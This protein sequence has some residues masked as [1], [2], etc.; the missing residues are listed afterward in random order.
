MGQSNQEPA[1]FKTATEDQE[2]ALWDSRNAT[3]SRYG[4]SWPQGG[5]SQVPTVTSL[6]TVSLLGAP[7]T[8][9]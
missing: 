2:V 1:N 7:N 4:G 8:I 6:G 9:P 5:R 3:S